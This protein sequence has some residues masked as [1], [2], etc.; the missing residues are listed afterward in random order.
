MAE[1]FGN[2]ASFESMGLV[3]GP[4]VRFVVFLQGCPLRCLYC[5]NPEMW[6][7][8]DEKMKYTPQ[9]LLDKV[10]KYR[11]YFKNG[12]GV[13]LSGGEPLMQV[14]FAT[15]F[16]KLC[17][18]ENI[19]TCLDTSG[20][21][22]G[23]EELLDYCD[24]VILDVKAIDEK[25]YESLVGLKIDCFFKFLKVCQAKDKKM[26]LRQVVVPGINDDEKSVLKLKK[27]SQELKNVERIELLPYHDMAK[28]KYE[29]LGLKYRLQDTP[30]MD[31]SK[32]A[33]LQKL[34]K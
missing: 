14:E 7:K 15:E 6:N 21:G 31:K 17:K 32:C 12:G 30:N 33:D 18:K 34:L 1:V 20:V 26:W 8:S 19:N 9:Q 10:L 28:K 13:T 2:I 25:D 5:H 27:F 11:P 23:Y 24:L 16:F 3:D 29:G 22:D 4:G